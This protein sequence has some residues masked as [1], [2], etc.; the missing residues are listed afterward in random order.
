MSLHNIYLNIGSNIDPESNLPRALELL[1]RF[2]QIKAT[3]EVWESHAVGSGGPNFLN[4]SVL[5]QTN[6]APADFKNRVAL[7]IETTMGRVRTEDKN[8]PRPIDIDIM[9]ADDQ[10][11]NLD[12]WNN[13]FVLLPIAEL[14]PDKLHPTSHRSLRDAAE[15][16]RRETWIVP[17]PG[18]LKSPP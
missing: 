5:L 2:G 3:S 9:M 8:A 15:S 13:A 17:R 14:L 7:P 10:A 12:R 1:A 6:V 16:A 4:A 11:F 18:L